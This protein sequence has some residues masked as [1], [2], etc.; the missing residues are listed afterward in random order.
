MVRV[1]N[2]VIA[3]IPRRTN[4]ELSRLRREHAGARNG[5]R[6]GTHIRHSDV[7]YSSAADTRTADC[8]P[9]GLRHV[10]VR[11]SLAA[12]RRRGTRVPSTYGEYGRGR[13]TQVQLERKMTY[14]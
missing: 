2:P 13:K 11:G 6:S 8:R 10:P 1:K 14:R 12:S 5:A 4:H 3:L 7:R 9:R